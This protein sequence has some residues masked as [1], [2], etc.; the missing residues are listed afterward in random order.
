MPGRSG[1]LES[2]KQ[3]TSGPCPERRARVPR[4]P[5][6]SGPARDPLDADHDSLRLSAYGKRSSACHRL[7]WARGVQRSS[8]P[9]RARSGGQ[10]SHSQVDLPAAG[11]MRSMAAV[12]RSA[13]HRRL[14]WARGVQSNSHPGRAWSGG[15]GS[16]AR[17]DRPAARRLWIETAGGR[18][19]ARRRRSGARKEWSSSSAARL[20]AVPGATGEGPTLEWTSPLPA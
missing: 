6:L 4:S 19:A 12:G 17:V 1:V 16:H 18:S 11:R 10:G 2:A 13:V 8:P 7:G 20:W 3:L 15:L 9:G 5:S 14:S